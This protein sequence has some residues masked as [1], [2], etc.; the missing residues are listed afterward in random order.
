MSDAALAE[1]IRHYHAGDLPGAEHF[2]RDVLVIDPD[3]ITAWFMIGVTC[4]R[5]GKPAEAVAGY[6][7]AL[8][9]KPDLVEAHENL[10]R[11]LEQLGK[12]DE[13]VVCYRHAQRLRPESAAIGINLG[14][15]LRVLGRL[16]E[17]VAVLE[18]AVRL[19][20]DLPEGFNNLGAVRIAQGQLAEAATC[21][22]QALLLRPEYPEALNNL[23]YVLREQGHPDEAE[24]H[25]RHALQLKP[26]YAEAFAN[27]GIALADMEYLNEAT[28]CYRQALTL[29][30]TNADDHVNLGGAL[31]LQGN[32]E[33]AVASFEQALRLR[34]GHAL[35]Q[36]GLARL[37]LEGRYPP[38]GQTAAQ[39]Q[40]HLAGGRLSPEHRTIVLFTLSRLLDK[41]GA[42]DEAFAYYRQA[43][44]AGRLSYL[45][46]GT[47]F[48][49]EIYRRQIDQIVRTFDAEFFGRTAAFGL[50]AEMPVFIIGMPRSGTTLVEQILA[51][52]PRVVGA[53]ELHAFQQLTLEL[54]ELLQTAEEYP[55]CLAQLDRQAAR[56]L[57]KRHLDY[58][59]AVAGTCRRGADPAV[60]P[61]PTLRC[62]WRTDV[63]RAPGAALPA[64]VIDKLPMNFLRVGLIHV[65]FPK[66][67][68]IHCRRD[69]LDVCLSCYFQDFRTLNFA[70]TLAD[71]GFVYK[72][73]E[74]LMEHWGKVLPGRIIEVVYEDLVA[75]QKAVS[76]Q[77]V[78]H[79]G[80]EWD[81]RCLAFHDNRRTV[82][83]AST[84]Q[85]RRPIYKSAIA[86]WKRYAAHLGPLFEALQS[87]RLS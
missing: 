60:A 81:D 33:E 80:L 51:S 54:S 3:N 46:S 87:P 67:R 68:I 4:H 64:R 72:Q 78:A 22:R 70:W 42:Y 83:T 71:I 85:V 9:L 16:D 73:Y 18:Q 11:V 17:A 82:R 20:P 28:A 27:L 45:R 63:V 58:L 74:R 31:V 40:D 25:Y 84:L 53:G 36:C 13:A 52:H 14:N 50:D 23:G 66:A 61:E 39:L 35:A 48:N 59:E 57:A 69:P 76:R 21:L 79:C 6:Q 37:S 12:R 1:A 49:A 43:N 19:G 32:L 34:P 15:T 75:D 30:P 77:L 24:V 29:R 55:Q 2:C 5:Q 38:N 56:T 44:E 26:D 10:A 41:Q 7:E 47:E 86:R 65:L 8:R 62:N